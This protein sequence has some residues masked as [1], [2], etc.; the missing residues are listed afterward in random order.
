M[1][2]NFV[3]E[4][5]ELQEG[6][7]ELSKYLN[8]MLGD[9]GMM[10]SVMQQDNADLSVCVRNG[11][12]TIVYDK[13]IHFFRAYSL[14]VQH[15]A[16]GETDFYLQEK[17]QF[18][19]N[20]PMFDV[21]QGNAVIKVAEIKK[22]LC[23]MAQMGLNMLMVYCEDSFEVKA[24][25][26]FG[27]MRSRYTETE[28]RECDIYAD[29]FGIE[30]IPCIQTLAHLWDVLKWD[31]VYSDIRE[32]ECCL[33]V[34]EEKTYKFI[35]DII[36]ASARPFH[37]KRIHIGMDE[38]YGLGRGSFQDKNGCMKPQEIMRLHLN[39]VLQIVH[40][41]GLK[42]MMW[43]DMF[44]SDVGYYNDKMEITQERI[45][46]FP[47]GVQMVYWDYYHNEESFYEGAIARHRLFGEPVFAGGIWT[48]VGYGPHW[49]RTFKSTEAA[50]N[51]CKREGIR[52][53]FATVWGDNGTECL[54]NTN[55]LGLALYGEH[56]YSDTI[57][58]E[59]LKKRFEFITG[60]N[61]DDFL[62]L[63]GFDNIP[64]VDNIATTSY[65]P[66]KYLMW[67]DILSGLCDKN[68]EGLPLDAHYAALAERLKPACERNG[69]Y[70]EL[71]RMNYLVAHTL[72]IKSEL[73][74]RVTSAYKNGDKEELRHLSEVELPELK[75]RV[76]RLRAC[77]MENWFKLY[78]SL[79]WD[80]MDM[81]YGSLLSRIDS[82]ITE[83]TMYLDGEMER[84]EELEEERLY[85]NGRPG[86]IDY[87]NWYGRTV[88]ASRIA[89]FC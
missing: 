15:L 73:G 27:Y 34:G 28:L 59:K 3:N 70:N 6:I 21:S 26:Y 30:M 65:N 64:G 71:F 84:L 67:Q 4:P 18:D 55:I 37:T 20:G 74:L 51:V 29:M 63:E 8:V 22:T 79:G 87:L 19:L 77:H 49:E 43:S 2:L 41:L 10:I 11:E 31:N 32:N 76:T 88:S 44:F 78:K 23:Q 75:N 72:A 89:S 9:D 1:K 56:G 42:P 85:F 58:Y 57:D 16:E 33:L 13:K 7:Q 24:Q 83:I 17:P 39:R 35:R 61:Y 14:L 66:S 25:P 82:T 60:A 68:I 81:R 50:L 52:E 86:M 46:C 80:V 12:A 62:A 69:A 53:V 54:Y 38:A 45:D 36:E 5:W 47:E 40:E 48:W